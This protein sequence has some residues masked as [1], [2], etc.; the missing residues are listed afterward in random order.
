[1]VMGITKG[2]RI[3]SGIL[4]LKLQIPNCKSQKRSKPQ[5]PSFWYLVL[6][7]FW[8]LALGISV[9]SLSLLQPS[10]VYH[11]PWSSRG[12]WNPDGSG[13]ARSRVHLAGH[14]IPATGYRSPSTV[15]R[16][17]STVYRV[18]WCTGSLNENELPLLS[19]LLRL[20]VALWISRIFFTM[21][22]PNPELVLLVSLSCSVMAADLE[23]LK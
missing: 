18:Y 21:A 10:T 20:I 23:K 9:L 3:Y 13:Q 19:L 17:P 7:V 4:R 2:A 22:K 11:Q 6:F 8:N 15:H 12:P 5:I 1:M 14:R 16:P